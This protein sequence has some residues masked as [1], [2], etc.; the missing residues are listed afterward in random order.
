MIEN[1]VRQDEWSA[2]AKD[3]C[4][5]PVDTVGFLGFVANKKMVDYCGSSRSDI[6][7]DHFFKNCGE[8]RAPLCCFKGPPCCMAFLKTSNDTSVPNREPS[9]MWGNSSITAITVDSL[10]GKDED[11]SLTT[12][13][14][15]ST[16]QGNLPDHNCYM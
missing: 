11:A 13:K 9:S 1:L 14:T 15:G 3:Y 5:I 2:K 8:I 10:P 12:L 16:R 4:Q 7:R 6:P